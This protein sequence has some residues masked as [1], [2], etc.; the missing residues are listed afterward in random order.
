LDNDAFI[1]N[2]RSNIPPEPE[3]ISPLDQLREF[4]QWLLIVP[5]VMVL[6]FGCGQ[7]A[8]F[9]TST[10]AYADTRSALE[11]EYAPWPFLSIRAIRPEIVEEIKLDQE[12]ESDPGEVFSLPATPDDEWVVEPLP[13]E[14]VVAQ[15]PTEDIPPTSEPGGSLPTATSYVPTSPPTPGPGPTFAPSPTQNPG[16]TS[17]P[18]GGGPTSTSPPSSTAPPTFTATPVPTAIPS[19]TPTDAPSATAPPTSTSTPNP[20][21]TS[22]PPPPNYCANISWNGKS[23]SDWQSMGTVIKFDFQFKNNNSIPMTLTSYNISWTDNGLVLHRTKAQL[24]AGSKPKIVNSKGSS[25]AS[26]TGCPQTFIAQPGGQQEIYNM[27]CENTSCVE[28]DPNGPPIPS[29]TY[30]FTATGNF[31]FYGSSTV[32]CGFNKSGSITMP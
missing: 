14:V 12:S 6:L 16:P 13:T 23:V 21:A 27:F 31:A 8:L 2:L 22:P 18:G 9:T 3:V 11:A 26:C 10:T 4:S 25:P 24:G 28:E 15:A 32:N 7:L 30:N 29:G 20:T 19:S 17:P 5:L 1:D